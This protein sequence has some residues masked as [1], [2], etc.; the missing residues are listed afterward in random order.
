[1][2]RF[3]QDANTR[4]QA[5]ATISNYDSIADIGNIRT[6]VAPS[7]SYTG[8]T[9]FTTRPRNVALM[10][11]IKAL[12]TDHTRVLNA[13]EK[14][15]ASGVATLDVN[16]KLNSSQLPTNVAT[17][18][19]NGL[20][21][22]SMGGAAPGAVMPYAMS[23]PPT[24]W[25]ECNG[26]T[27]SRTTY[28]NLFAAIGTTFGSGNGSTTFTIPDLRGEFIRGWAHGKTVANESARALGN[29][30]DGS[31]IPHMMSTNDQKIIYPGTQITPT[32]D[33]DVRVARSVTKG[34]VATSSW[35]ET[36]QP[37]YTR[38]RP[39]NVA[40]MFCIKY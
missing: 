12:T 40:L 5:Q 29:W 15:I 7:D 3:S 34:I 6:A 2:P 20:L 8:E 27:I 36:Y 37:N 9:T 32:N 21:P 16:A 26:S 10:Y 31:Q 11:C 4:Y 17:L 39:R 28:A 1:M 38:V 33:D 24:G 18:G 35:S 13:G 14:G 22:S 19:E 30:Q 23:I 25:L